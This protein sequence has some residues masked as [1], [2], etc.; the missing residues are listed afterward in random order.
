MHKSQRYLA[1]GAIAAGLT[2]MLVFASGHAPRAP[3]GMQDVRSPDLLPSAQQR[4]LSRTAAPTPTGMDKALA[5]E[6]V[7]DV[8]SFGRTVNWL[9]ITQAN[10]DLSDTCPVPGGDPDAACATLNAA[11]AVTTFVYEDLAHIT[12]PGKS[13]N[14][15]LCHWF[16]PFLNVT[17]FNPTGAPV[18]ARLSYSPTLTIES[19]VLADPALIDPTTGLP[20]SGKLLT[21]MTSSE[22]FEVPLAAGQQL[23]ERSRDTATCIAGFITRRALSETYGL[24]DAQIKLFFKKP[25]TVRMNVSG[26]V[27][28]VQNASLIFGL[29]IVGD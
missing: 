24:T 11:P 15:L 27:Q 9:G 26:N 3:M 12:L 14:S 29:R 2:S 18:V 1:F 5:P 4:H 7:G 28:Y 16:S 22:R 10:I 21:G 8:D 6:D 23:F 13:A 20:F 19:E 17:Y 25:I